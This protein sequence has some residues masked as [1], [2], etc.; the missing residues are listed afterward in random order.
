MVNKRFLSVKRTLHWVNK[1]AWNVTPFLFGRVL[2]YIYIVIESCIETVIYKLSI[3]EFFKYIQLNFMSISYYVLFA[4]SKFTKNNHSLCLMSVCLALQHMT[5][6]KMI[7]NC[8]SIACRMGI[9]CYFCCYC[10]NMICCYW[11]GHIRVIMS[12]YFSLRWIITKNNK[13]KYY[14]YTLWIANHS[15]LIQMYDIFQ[16][17]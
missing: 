7:K 3:L 11:W 9:E 14:H 8:Q 12:L 5:R 2:S 17:F 4:G 1:K 6:S 13:N 16:H 10:M 15:F